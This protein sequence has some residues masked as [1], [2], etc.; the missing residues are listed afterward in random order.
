MNNL[1]NGKIVTEKV[2]LAWF[3][4]LAIS[5]A[6]IDKGEI[7][8]VRYSAGMLLLIPAAKG[9]ILSLTPRRQLCSMT[10]QY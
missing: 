1:S 2:N 6:R 7:D 3:A 5:K 4:E 8:Y 9:V 10:A